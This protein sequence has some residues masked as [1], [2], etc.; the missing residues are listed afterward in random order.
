MIYWFTGQPGSGKTTLA[1]RLVSHFEK[2]GK[3]VKHIDGD[4]LRSLTQN[5]DYTEQG[6]R[7]NIQAAQKIASEFKDEGCEVVVSVVAPYLD[8]REKFKQEEAVVEFYTHTTEIRGKEKYKVGE[9]EVPKNN[10]TSINTDLEIEDCFRVILMKVS[11]SNQFS[12]FVGRYQPLHD[13]HKWLFEQRLKEGKN[14]L[15]CVRDVPMNEVNPFTAETVQKNIIQQ[16]QSMHA[17]GR[18]KVII[19]PDIESINYG[20]GVG[21]D[22][23]EHKPPEHIGKISA[24]EIRK[25]M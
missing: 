10:F 9:Y 5:F 24:T 16:Y 7:Q 11:E 4:G 8:L 1:K 23:I 19:I 3:C 18:V 17:K 2:L 13:G 20:R 6:R 21:Y 14:I 22:I 25:K 12:M 15:I